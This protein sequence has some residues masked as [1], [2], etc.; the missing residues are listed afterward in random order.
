SSPVVT[1]LGMARRSLQGPFKGVTRPRDSG[2]IGDLTLSFNLLRRDRCLIIRLLATLQ[3]S[4]ANYLLYAHRGPSL[5]R[6]RWARRSAASP[7]TCRP[8]RRGSAGPTDSGHFPV[9]LTEY[10]D[11]AGLPRPAADRVS[12]RR[13]GAEALGGGGARSRNVTPGPPQP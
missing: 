5:G 11:L 9:R 2:G 10:N 13:R 8:R 6:S 7:G 4:L 12:G 3:Y 1:L